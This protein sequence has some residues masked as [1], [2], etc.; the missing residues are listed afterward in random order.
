MLRTSLVEA[1]WP[2]EFKRDFNIIT[3]ELSRAALL[4][5]LVIIEP[6]KWSIKSLYK[7]SSNEILWVQGRFLNRFNRGPWHPDPYRIQPCQ[8][9]DWYES[10]NKPAITTP[11]SSPRK[12]GRKNAIEQTFL[13]TARCSPPWIKATTI[14]F[15]KIRILSVSI[16]RTPFFQIQRILVLCYICI[17]ELI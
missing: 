15:L 1:E 14:F 3:R 17:C 7:K 12:G 13:T 8:Q 5:S 10:I 4:F 9:Y 2:V 11:P 6:S 16:L